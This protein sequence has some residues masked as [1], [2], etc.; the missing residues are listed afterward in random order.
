MVDDR[1]PPVA[2]VVRK[3]ARRLLSQYYVLAPPPPLRAA[4]SVWLG[5]SFVEPPAS[6]II[7]DVM[8]KLRSG[9][10]GLVGSETTVKLYRRL[11]SVGAGAPNFQ[12]QL[13][14]ACGC[15]VARRF[16]VFVD[17]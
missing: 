1:R 15:A 2:A 9:G 8:G 3:A 14:A 6:L 17:F 10:G 13:G 5:V 12:P 16:L 7:I 11:S 4:A